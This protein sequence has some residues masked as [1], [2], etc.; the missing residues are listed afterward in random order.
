MGKWR[1]S[2]QFVQFAL[3]KLECNVEIFPIIELV[4]NLIE[5]EKCNPDCNYE[6]LSKELTGFL[7]DVTTADGELHDLE[8]IFIQW[9]EIGLTKGKPGFLEGLRSA[10]G[11]SQRPEQP[12]K[13]KIGPPPDPDSDG[14]ALR[15]GRTDDGSSGQDGQQTSTMVGRAFRGTL[16]W[17]TT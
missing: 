5:L 6:A 10:V 17:L 11:I 12:A 15:G 4:D 13:G 16:H 8:V 7:Q 3:P 2:E 1:Y 9:L 14:E